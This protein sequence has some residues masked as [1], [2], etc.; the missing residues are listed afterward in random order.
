VGTRA[1]SAE[2]TD[3]APP[4]IEKLAEALKLVLRKGLPVIPDGCPKL[5]LQLRGVRAR[6]IDHTD[7]LSRVK[8]LNALLQSLLLGLGDSE[9]AQ[10][11]QILFAARGAERGTTLTERRS[12]A[13]K[14]GD[15][16]Y[17]DTHFRKHI[18]PRLVRDLA[19]FLHEDSQNYTP[20]TQY[21]PAPTEISGDTPALTAADVNEQEELVSRI[22]AVVY[23]L[24]AE[25]IHRALVEEAVGP[26]QTAPA[27]PWLVA[28][29]L[30]HIH[31]YLEQY[32]QRI[33]HGDAEFRA[34]GLIRLAGWTSEVT[35]HEATTLR[36][37]LASVQEHDCVAF[38]RL[39]AS[40]SED[41]PTF[42]S[43]LSHD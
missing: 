34:E 26:P 36:M 14:V 19:W 1:K 10:A 32:G 41:L 38:A 39:A 3:V 9:E 6:A 12:R 16:D 33:M 40:H 5:L 25:L 27:I 11:L 42:A 20:R 21:A 17:D 2:R 30:T 7:Y 8:A 18:E 43:L 35:P 24:R 29:L 28:R 23:E 22:W 15:W 31:R 13:A 4:P 37:L